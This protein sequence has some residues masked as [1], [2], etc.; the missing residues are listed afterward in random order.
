MQLV[1]FEKFWPVSL[2]LQVIGGYTYYHVFVCTG[3]VCTNFGGFILITSGKVPHFV[4]MDVFLN[5]PVGF[6]WPRER[7]VQFD[8]YWRHLTRCV[9]CFQKYSLFGLT[10]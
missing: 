2:S 4:I 7:F 6:D 9:V 3:K 1:G 10:V 5:I 8:F